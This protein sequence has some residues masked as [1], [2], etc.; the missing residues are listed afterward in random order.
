[1]SA[2]TRMPVCEVR[3]CGKPAVVVMRAPMN[4]G[5]EQHFYCDGHAWWISALLGKI[6][7]GYT[8]RA[9]SA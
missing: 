3:G 6:G 7:A 4:G 5:G 1:M 8:Y 2:P 9:L